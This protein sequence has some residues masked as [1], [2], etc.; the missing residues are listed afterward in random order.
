MIH[1][2]DRTAAAEDGYLSKPHN[3]ARS[4]DGHNSFRLDSSGAQITKA[5]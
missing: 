1:P 5:E 2:V 3:A 4:V